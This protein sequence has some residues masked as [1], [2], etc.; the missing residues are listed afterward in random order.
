MIRYTEQHF[1][2]RVEQDGTAIAGDM[3]RF[4]TLMNDDAY[5][6]MLAT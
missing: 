3:V 5:Q 4:E 6:A 2:V 1:W